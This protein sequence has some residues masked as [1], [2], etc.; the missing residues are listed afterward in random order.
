M[1]T[2]TYQSQSHLSKLGKPGDAALRFGE[3]LSQDRWAVLGIGL[4]DLQPLV[5]CY[6]EPW[7]QEVLELLAELLLSGRATYGTSRD[8]V[9]RLTGET[10][11]VVTQASKVAQWEEDLPRGFKAGVL[12]TIPPAHLSQGMV[13]PS[14]TQRLPMLSL[15]IGIVTDQDGPFSTPRDLLNKVTE[16][17]NQNERPALLFDLSSLMVTVGR[18]REEIQVAEH[19]PIL[20]PLI[21]RFAQVTTGP[22]H[23]LRNGLNIL[24]EEARKISEV[25]WQAAQSDV[26]FASTRYSRLLLETC[27]EIRFRGV[28]TPHRVNLSQLLVENEPLWIHKLDVDITVDAPSESVD[29]YADRSRVEQ[30]L[31][32]LLRWLV[33]R[34]EGC[35]TVSVMCRKGES[36][37][38]VIVTGDFDVTMDDDSLVRQALDELQTQQPCLYVFQKLVARH[39]GK[40][41]FQPG[42]ITLSF[43]PYQWQDVRSTEFL[44]ERIESLRV[45]AE[46]LQVHLDKILPHRDELAKNVSI[47]SVVALGSQVIADLV[48]EFGL[49]RQEARIR[50]PEVGNE[51]RALCESLEA[52]SHFCQILAANL[53]A[54][55]GEF[56]PSPHATD[57]VGV[58][59]SVRL[60]LHSKI[61]GIAELGWDVPA[62]LPPVR[63]TDTALAQV[64]I[65]LALN[66]LEELAH[67]RPPVSRLSFVARQT[68]DGVQ[69]DISDTGEGLPPEVIERLSEESIT[70]RQHVEAGIGLHVVKSI[71]DELG[72]RIDFQSMVGEGTRASIILP[73]WDRGQ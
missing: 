17:R 64:V 25:L 21:E 13:C 51:H 2:D 23:D 12:Q 31:F 10:F 52:G 16:A 57:V 34:G 54:L 35:R 29:I 49:I 67:V 20:F 41:Q 9:A 18:L 40:V 42:R 6:G 43:P 32:S 53:L 62:D 30:A 15:A 27:S 7:R 19:A 72:G 55:E 58:L 48:D 3:L 28:G 56:I 5:E 24:Y 66:S 36:R 65:N 37:G 1:S 60:M 68:H 44:Q 73:I 59:D 8:L 33:G 4:N 38:E 70:T 71:L 63:A 14:P 47:G 61:E 11:L 39:E 50:M 69:I 46:E 45:E 22:I 26:L